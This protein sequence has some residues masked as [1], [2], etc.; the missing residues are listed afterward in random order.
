MLVIGENIN[1]SNSAVAG[2]IARRD[3]D[4][5]ANLASAQGASGADFI[6]VNASSGHGSL[7][8]NVVDMTWLIKTV[9]SATNKPLAIDSDS[10]AVIEA[11]LSRYQGDKIII[12]SVTA[13]PS[14]LEPIGPLAAKRRA[15]LVALAMGAEGIPETAEQRLA[16]CD[17]IMTNL[18]RF[19][20]EEEQVLFDPLVL[21][22]S[23]DSTQGLVT[24]KTIEQI[25]ARFPTAR[26]VMGLSNISYGM[27]N[28]KLINRSFLL[29]A[30]YAGLDAAILDPLDTRTMSVVKVSDILSGKDP[31]CKAYLRAHR[32]GAIVE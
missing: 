26:T 7:K 19:G 20:V 2:A 25:K 13:E 5:I 22:I 24:L 21:P 17:T 12:N 1:A 14:R 18:L 11:A 10:P 6:D 8:D 15:W 29:M 16:A 4:F 23:V 30:T 31:L 3:E 32:R 27:P 9:Q 28:R